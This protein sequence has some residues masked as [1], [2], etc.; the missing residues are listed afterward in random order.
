MRAG[1][2][3]DLLQL[4]LQ[5]R[6]QRGRHG[7]IHKHLHPRGLGRR[8][9]RVVILRRCQLGQ[10]RVG[11][12]QHLARIQMRAARKRVIKPRCRGRIRLGDGGHVVQLLVQRQNQRVL[13]RH[14]D[15]FLR[16]PGVDQLRVDVAEQRDI[17]RPFAGG[18]NIRAVGLGENE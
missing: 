18:R 10:I 6:H 11:R 2:I 7:V 12:A 13:R 3:A 1:N 16:G 14:R 4:R 15:G 9:R 5:I 17:T 8:R